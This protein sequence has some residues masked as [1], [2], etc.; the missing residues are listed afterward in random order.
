MDR[1]RELTRDEI[2]AS[3]DRDIAVFLRTMDLWNEYSAQGMGIFEACQ[4][5]LEQA[6]KE[7]SDGQL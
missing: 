5:A 2:G 6:E 3:I 7:A 1:T 4:K